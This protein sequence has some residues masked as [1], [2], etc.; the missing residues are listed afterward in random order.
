LS[1]AFSAHKLA[2]KIIA[3]ITSIT[4]H[5][6]LPNEILTIGLIRIADAS[7]N[8][9]NARVENIRMAYQQDSQ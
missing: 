8:T 2:N 9:R 6:A 5:N 4:F 3:Q 1:F 7:Q